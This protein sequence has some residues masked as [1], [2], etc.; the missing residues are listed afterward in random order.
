MRMAATATSYGL[1]EEPLA[2]PEA[3][4]H[5]DPARR[6]LLDDSPS[7]GDELGPDRVELRMRGVDPIR[8]RESHR[9]EFRA[10]ATSQADSSGRA[11]DGGSAVEPALHPERTDV[12]P[13]LDGVLVEHA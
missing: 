13:V 10:P 2:R 3:A 4:S 6:D 8:A 5:G 11:S 1:R 7:I 12:G 9:R